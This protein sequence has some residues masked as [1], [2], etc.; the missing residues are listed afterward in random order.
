MGLSDFPDDVVESIPFLELNVMRLVNGRFTFSIYRKSCHA[1][2]YLHAFSYQPR[3][4]KSSVIRSQFLRAYRFCDTQFLKNEVQ[5]I[6]QS[7][8]V[9]GYTSKFIEECRASAYK[10]RRHEIQKEHLLALEE[11]PFASHASRHTEKNEPLATLTLVYHPRNEK[12]KPRLHEMGIR[13]AFSTN[14]TLRQQLKHSSTTCEP[15]GSVYVVNCKECTDVYIGQTGKHV[16]DRMSEHSRAP[17]YNSGA[18]G[19]MVKHSSTH[20]RIMSMDLENPIKV[21]KSDCSHTRSTVEAA[22]IHVAPT[23]EGNT[24]TSSTRS[25]DLVAP[26]ICRSTNFDWQKLSECIPHINKNLIPKFKRHLFGRQEVMRPAS[27]I[28]SRSPVDPIA[29]RTR[30]RQLPVQPS[31]PP[32]NL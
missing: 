31:E 12:L 29:H 1:G 10:G 22:L 17:N 21:F 30:G 3:S 5:S 26:V 18:D 7:F 11:L 6:R 25:D 13:L 16:E 27:S 15:K 2:N 24:A 20:G 19:A 14:S 32:R 23:V 8:L 28:R 4:H 9:L